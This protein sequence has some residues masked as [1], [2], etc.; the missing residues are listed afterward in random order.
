[1]E[2]KIM[3][4]E[5]RDLNNKEIVI[6]KNDLFNLLDEI[7]DHLDHVEELNEII[8]DLNEIILAQKEVIRKIVNIKG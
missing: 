5:T 6:S 7:Q 4:I 3:N 2:V 8:D 1:M